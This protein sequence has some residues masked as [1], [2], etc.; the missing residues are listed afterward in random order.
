MLR[1]SQLH[2][3]I[4]EQTAPYFG[5]SK[6]SKERKGKKKTKKIDNIY[7]TLNQ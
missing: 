7:E 5:R 2:G 6:S 1:E 3:L 4:D